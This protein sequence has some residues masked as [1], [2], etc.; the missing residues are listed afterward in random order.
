V[1]GADGTIYT[2]AGRYTPDLKPVGSR[3]PHE[4]W[5]H[6]PVPAAHGQFFIRVPPNARDDR[7]AAPHGSV[8]LYYADRPQPL[9]DL[10]GLSG[11][12]LPTENNQND[13]ERLPF[14]ERAFLVPDAG[15][16][17][18]LSADGKQFVFH[19]I[20]ALGALKKAGAKYLYIA[21]RPEA[22]VVGTNYVFKPDVRSSTPMADVSR[23]S[24]PE[25][26][27]FTPGGWALWV[28]PRELAGTVVELKLRISD[29]NETVTETFQIPVLS[30]KPTAWPV[31]K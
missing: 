5:H 12:D 11:L 8:G 29:A 13:P 4:S 10:S 30:A 22:A 7:P 1:P 27:T 15:V 24:G 2:A 21:N 28:P 19:R 31:P 6:A 20:D 3:V 25:G 26:L 17:A 16:L 23:V 9:L 14:Y 18:V